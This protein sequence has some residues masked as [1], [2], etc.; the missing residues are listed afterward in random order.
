V[1]EPRPGAAERAPVPPPPVP[2]HRAEDQT[3]SVAL[4]DAE[5]DDTEPIEQQEQEREPATN[6]ERFA[7][8]RARQRARNAEVTGRDRRAA[9]EARAARLAARVGPYAGDLGH[10]DD[11]EHDDDI[12]GDQRRLRLNYGVARRD[13]S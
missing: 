9:Q 11:D 8:G 3:A 5:E 6:F 4:A 2:T 7:L 1:E 12:A 10:E 13:R